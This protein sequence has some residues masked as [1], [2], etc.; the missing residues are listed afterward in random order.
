MEQKD[1][2]W[3]P[4]GNTKWDLQHCLH[5]IDPD[6]DEM[7]K[8]NIVMQNPAVFRC[9]SV[10]EDMNCGKQGTAVSSSQLCSYCTYKSCAEWESGLICP[11]WNP[12]LFSG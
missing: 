8:L 3:K 4:A 7:M 10:E 9:K 5:S 1:G 11:S 6:K 12:D 2:V